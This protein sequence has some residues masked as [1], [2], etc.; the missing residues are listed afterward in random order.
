MLL[1]AFYSLYLEP[2]ERHMVTQ[3]KASRSELPPQMLYAAV[4]DLVEADIKKRGTLSRHSIPLSLTT[5]VEVNR[6]YFY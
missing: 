5:F 2:F 1:K 3:V 4:L 6:V